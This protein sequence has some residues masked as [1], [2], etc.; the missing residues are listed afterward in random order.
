MRRPGTSPTNIMTSG[1]PPAARR[2]VAAARRVLA[3]DGFGAITVEAVTAEAGA[4][5]DS[6]RYYFGSKSGLIAAVVD[7]I[8]TDQSAESSRDVGELPPGP[9]RVHALVGADRRLAADSAAIQDFF[10]LLPHVL[11]DDDLRSRVAALYGWYREQYL[12]AFGD[13]AT[14]EASREL[15]NYASLMVAVIDG[16]AIQKALDPGGVD[17]DDVFDLWERLLHSAGWLGPSAD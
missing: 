13:A 1:L 17:L 11:Q 15:Q 14:E 6:V 7:A 5:R 2:L 9:Q 4:Y 12:L 16:L 10:R 3:R 8:S